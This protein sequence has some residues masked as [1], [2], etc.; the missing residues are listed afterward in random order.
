LSKDEYLV[1]SAERYVN[2][3]SALPDEQSEIRFTLKHGDIKTVA[4]C[5]SWD[6]KNN[7][8]KL[9][10][11]RVYRLK[12]GEVTR[13][14]LSADDIHVVLSVEKESLEP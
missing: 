3:Y 11:G 7:C 9:E 10:V 1:V 14:L 8:G 5:Q 2:K 13:D 12:R 4:R 6:P